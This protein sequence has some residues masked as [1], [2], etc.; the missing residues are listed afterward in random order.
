MNPT[1]V[2]EAPAQPSSRSDGRGE[3]AAGRGADARVAGA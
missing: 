2:I 3:R 1:W